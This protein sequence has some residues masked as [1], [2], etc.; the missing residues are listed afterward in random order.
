MIMNKRIQH[1]P[2]RTY[3]RENGVALFAALMLLL[4]VTIL[5]ISSVRTGV[6]EAQMSTNEELRIAA[7]ETAESTLDAVV[8]NPSNTQ[9]IGA[10]GRKV[11]TSNW[12]TACDSNTVIIPPVLVGTVD[13]ANQLMAKVIRLSPAIG[14]A[15]PGYSVIKYQSATFRAQARYNG[16]PT[17]QGN[18][19]VLEGVIIA[20]PKPL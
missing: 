17:G 19:E 8:S 9:V 18:T 1:L 14:P 10:V 2:T 11:C 15:P 5:G 13:N 3:R 16:T 12:P 4:I 6:M 7:F 20:F